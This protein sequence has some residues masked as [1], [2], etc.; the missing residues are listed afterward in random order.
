MDRLKSH[1]LRLVDICQRI[2]DEK[3]FM[4][5]SSNFRKQDLKDLRV[6]L[7][8]THC[9]GYDEVIKQIKEIIFLSGKW[10]SLC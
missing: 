6:R 8:V 9:T 10:E 7:H 5:G 2:I 3:T 1:L 4:R